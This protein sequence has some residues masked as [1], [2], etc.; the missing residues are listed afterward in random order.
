[1]EKNKKT[2]K[3]QKTRER[4]RERMQI[5]LKSIACYLHVL[6]QILNPIHVVVVSSFFI[7]VKK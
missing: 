2:Q 6:E 4:K 7:L 1:M 5:K 3:A